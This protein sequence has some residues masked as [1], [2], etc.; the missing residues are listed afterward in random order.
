[1]KKILIVEDDSVLCKDF[2]KIFSDR[3]KILIA[4]TGTDGLGKSLEWLPD[5]IILDIMLPGG[6]NGFDVL[7][8]LKSRQETKDIPV[9]VYTKLEDEQSSAIKGGASTY[10]VKSKTSVKRVTEVVDRHLS[11]PRNN[12]I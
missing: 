12:S 1:M 3:Y 8:K 7:R 11:T 2:Q 5:L 4:N 6:M 9:I 10:L